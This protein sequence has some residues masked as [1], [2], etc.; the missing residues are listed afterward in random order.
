MLSLH[1][2]CDALEVYMPTDRW[3]FIG[4]IYAILTAQPHSLSVSSQTLSSALTLMAR[5]KVLE[6][7]H[8]LNRHG[9]EGVAYRRPSVLV[10]L[11]EEASE[12]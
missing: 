7:E 9:I 12:W 8:R 3:L 10:R 11:A 5:L 1:E 2:T 4:A 6:S